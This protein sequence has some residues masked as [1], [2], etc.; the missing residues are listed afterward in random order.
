LIYEGDIVEYD[1]RDG[2][3]EI[4]WDDLDCSFYVKTNAGWADIFSDKRRWNRLEVV[5][6][7]FENP[8]LINK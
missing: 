8:E 4:C 1:G 7:I 3:G 2:V 6:N 5:G